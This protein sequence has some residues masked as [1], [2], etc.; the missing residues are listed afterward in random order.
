MEVILIVDLNSISLANTGYSLDAVSMLVQRRRRWANIETALS[1]YPVFAEVCLKRS[2]VRACC[3]LVG[4]WNVVILLLHLPSFVVFTEWFVT[5]KFQP[6]ET[7]LI[8]KL[9]SLQRVNAYTL[10]VP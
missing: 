2:H 9:T 10:Y 5:N 8:I 6:F 4:L 7:N 3:D 1:E